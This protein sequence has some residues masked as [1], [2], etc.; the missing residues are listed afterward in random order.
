MA[1]ITTP[2]AYPEISNADYHRNPLLTPTPSVSSSGLKTILTKSP[3][4]YWHDSILNVNRPPEKDKAHFNIGKAAHDMLLLTDRWADAYHITPE[5]F[6]RKA[7]KAQADEIAAADAALADGLTVLTFDQAAMVR[8]MAVVI[9]SHPIASAAL[10]NG[11]PE[12]TLAWQDTE[13]GVWLKARPDFLP[14]RRQHV[15]DLKFMADGH[16]RTFSR[17]IASYGYHMSAALYADGIKAVFGEYPQSFYF[18]VVEKE[19]PY[20]VSLY[21]LPGEDIERGRVLNRAAIR[22]FADC[23]N[24]GISPEHWPGYASDVVPVGLPHWERKQIDE[25]NELAAAAWAEAA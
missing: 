3:A 1:L 4:H 17:S 12:V 13:T 14:H 19:A 9:R 24:K 7:T 11:A 22:T 21:Q 8:E 15:P 25:N 2:G 18:I 16:P 20:V 6:T 23:L 10:S 5:G